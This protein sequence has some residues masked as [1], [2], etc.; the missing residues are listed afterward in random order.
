M[1]KIF[2][3]IFLFFSLTMSV[4][5]KNVPLYTNSINQVGIGLIK[6]PQEFYIYEKPDLKSKVVTKFQWGQAEGS[7]INDTDY[8]DNF[9][10]FDPNK[11][12]AYM[13]VLTDSDGDGWYEIC[14]D[15]T[16]GLTG[17]VN[18]SKY[19]YYPWYSFF[20][21]Y[22]KQNGLYAFR[23]IPVELKR[24][25]SKPTEDSQVINTFENAKNIRVQIY[26]GNWVLVRV[27]DFE[28]KLMIGWLKWRNEDGKFN[29]FPLLK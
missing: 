12:Y 2:I 18:P 19:E 11:D 8:S 20:M 13:T 7:K 26:R 4:F 27:Y 23:N 29:Y 25:H 28:G 24:L 17:W 22:G 1:K 14:Y 21:K 15:Q 9:I 16:K 6:L 10:I 3:S 5:A